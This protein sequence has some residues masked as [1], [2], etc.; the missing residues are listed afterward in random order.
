MQPIVD[1]YN[2]YVK[3]MDPKDTPVLTRSTNNDMSTN[4]YFSMNGIEGY[5]DQFTLQEYFSGDDE[6]DDLEYRGY[7]NASMQDVAAALYEL[8]YVTC[9]GDL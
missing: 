6:P 5:V 2:E 8:A 3:D 4:Y 9:G 1:A 7:D